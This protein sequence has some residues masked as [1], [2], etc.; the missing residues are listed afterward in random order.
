MSIFLKE[1]WNK[2][3]IIN[4]LMLACYILQLIKTPKDTVNK[5]QL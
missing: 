4:D 2:S 5:K 3:L 1:S